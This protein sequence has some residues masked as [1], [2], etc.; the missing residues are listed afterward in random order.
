M[1]ETHHFTGSCEQKLSLIGFQGST[2]EITEVANSLD[3]MLR[4]NINYGTP[5]AGG[6]LNFGEPTSIKIT[7]LKAGVVLKNFSLTINGVEHTFGDITTQTVNLYNSGTIDYFT[8]AFNAM[9]ASNDKTMR[10]KAKFTPS[11][12]LSR[13]DDV[14]V[15]IVFNGTFFYLK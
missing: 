14:N 13:A 4:G 5:I 6:V 15:E 12:D 9:V 11:H 10:S 1:K 3:D 7:G 2:V 8:R